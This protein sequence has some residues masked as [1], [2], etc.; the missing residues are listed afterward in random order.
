VSELERTADFVATMEA[1]QAEILSHPRGSQ[2]R[3]VAE[4]KRA[5]FL[6]TYGRAERVEGDEVAGDE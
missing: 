6:R 5:E 2:A 3:V 4:H 1:M